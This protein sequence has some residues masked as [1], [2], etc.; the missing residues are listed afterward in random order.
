LDYRHVGLLLPLREQPLDDDWQ[1]V[2][3]A[4]RPAFAMSLANELVNVRDADLS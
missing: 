4:A 2:K 3:E 1:S